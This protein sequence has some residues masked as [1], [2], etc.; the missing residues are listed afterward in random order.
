M[1]EYEA[2]QAAKV[3]FRFDRDEW[4]FSFTSD[5][6]FRFGLETVLTIYGIA[7]FVYTTLILMKVCRLPTEGDQG[8]DED[9]L[10][11][12]EARQKM[13]KEE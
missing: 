8:V 11:I 9:Q 4:D 12:D 2:I 6:I 3:Y 10:M 13:F 7:V 1:D 5:G